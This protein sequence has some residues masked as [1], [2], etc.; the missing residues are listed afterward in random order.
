[1]IFLLAKKCSIFVILVHSFR[2]SWQGS[3]AQQR[4][5]EITSPFSSILQLDLFKRRVAISNL[6]S[7]NFRAKRS[8]FKDPRTLKHSENQNYLAS[9]LSHTLRATFGLEEGT[10]LSFLSSFRAF[11][12]ARRETTFP[13]I[14]WGLDSGYIGWNVY[15]KRVCEV[16]IGKGPAWSNL[17]GIETS[18]IPYIVVTWHTWAFFSSHYIWNAAKREMGKL[19]SGLDKLEP[20]EEKKDKT[21]AAGAGTATKCM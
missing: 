18:P 21:A 10:S 19:P 4:A 11:I 16:K 3:R 1:M 9:F 13:R 6:L 20:Q 5:G 7:N 17:A 14:Y 8:L 12:S 2:G 15:T